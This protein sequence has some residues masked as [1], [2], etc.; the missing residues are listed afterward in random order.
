MADLFWPMAL[1]G[2]IVASYSN[3]SIQSLGGM[4]A[5]F[6]AG[7]MMDRLHHDYRFMY[8]WAAG[9]QCL[10]LVFMMAVYRGWLQYGGREGRYVPPAT[11]PAVGEVGE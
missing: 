2:D 10:A 11:G 9:F 4:A 8:I 1:I 7:W 5:S 6:G 3:R